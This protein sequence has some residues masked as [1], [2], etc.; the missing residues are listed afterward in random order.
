MTAWSQ[1]RTEYK[2]QF[3]ALHIMSL[4]DEAVKEATL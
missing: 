4:E 1:K 2:R 3:I